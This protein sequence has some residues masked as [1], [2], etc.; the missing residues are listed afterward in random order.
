MSQCR[1]AARLVWKTLVKFVSSDHR[2]P[3]SEHSCS[4]P[5]PALRPLPPALC[6]SAPLPAI[7][8]C[9]APGVLGVEV[10]QALFDRAAANE[11]VARQEHRFNAAGDQPLRDLA[12][13]HVHDQTAP[14]RAERTGLIAAAVERQEAIPN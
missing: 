6:T 9:D 11:L 12:A 5:S 14:D 1:T 4:G 2:Q 10:L 3:P 8:R 7:P 13:Q